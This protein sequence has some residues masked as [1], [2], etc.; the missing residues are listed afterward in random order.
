M[1]AHLSMRSITGSEFVDEYLLYIRF[2]DC[3]QLIGF[4]TDFLFLQL[5]F[6]RVN[7]QNENQVWFFISEMKY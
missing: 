5:V 1:S 4:L 2:L 6:V 3:K 7:S